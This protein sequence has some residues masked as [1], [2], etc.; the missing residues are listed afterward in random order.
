MRIMGHGKPFESGVDAPEISRAKCQK[1][2]I[3]D[4]QAKRHL[5][6]LLRQP[7]TQ[8][9]DCGARDRYG[10]PLVW[11]RLRNGSTAGAVLLSEGYAVPWYP[12]R[13]MD[14]CSCTPRITSR[15]RLRFDSIWELIC[16]EMV[17]AG[18]GRVLGH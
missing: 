2:R 9:E 4:Q 7:G 8:I 10:R 18:T 12:G 5:E 3:L 15:F 1:E 16:M 17:D 6:E 13:S 11:V 14:W